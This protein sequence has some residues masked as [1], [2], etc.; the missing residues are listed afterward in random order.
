MM[1]T[2]Q[3]IGTDVNEFANSKPMPARRR[4]AGTVAAK[5][6]FANFDDDSDDDQPVVKK[7]IAKPVPKFEAIAEDEEENRA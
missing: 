3:R 1:D 5:K 6:A 2:R 4:G 7:P